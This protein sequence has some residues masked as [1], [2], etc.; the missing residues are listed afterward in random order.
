MTV[1]GSLL[2][3]WQV[4]DKPCLVVGG[5][6]VA[7]SRIEHLLRANGNITVISG[8]GNVDEAII[9]WANEG[10]IKL[11]QRDFQVSDLTMYHTSVDGSVNGLKAEGI[12]E[13]HYRAIDDLVSQRF[14]IVCTC[15]DDYDLSLK[16]YYQCKLLQLPV[17]IADKPKY[18]DFY[19]G[20]MYNRDNLQIMVSTNGKSPRLSKVVKDTIAKQF[21]DLDLNKAVENLG[22]LRSGLRAIVTNE[23]LESIDVRMN[24]IKDLTD[25]FT[26]R[27]W[28]ELELSQESVNNVLKYFPNYPPRDIEEFKKVLSQN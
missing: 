10:K 13:D 15:I 20:A 24:W 18:C 23:D 9:A 3:A 25:F 14:A 4:K 27:Q 11:F 19:F 6:N 2:L 1:A 17:N 28:S 22:A 5:G 7:V 21:D 26:L 12:T 8:T 16:I